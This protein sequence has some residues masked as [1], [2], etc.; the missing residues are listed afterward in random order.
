MPR[1]VGTV[2]WSRFTE[3]LCKHIF[4]WSPSCLNRCMLHNRTTTTHSCCS[5]HPWATTNLAWMDSNL[6]SAMPFFC[7]AF[8]TFRFSCK[9]VSMNKEEKLVACQRNI[10]Q[11]RVCNIL[12]GFPCLSWLL[13][14]LMRTN[15]HMYVIV[16]ITFLSNCYDNID[17]RKESSCRCNL[18]CPQASPTPCLISQLSLA[19]ER[20]AACIMTEGGVMKRERE[21]RERERETETERDREKE[22]DH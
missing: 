11:S 14:L 18:H 1:I 5:T 6:I 12:F 9:R 2:T 3:R 8:R 22:R 13:H 21:D 20:V 10:K 7:I 19:V 15:V 16:V 17:T 4:K